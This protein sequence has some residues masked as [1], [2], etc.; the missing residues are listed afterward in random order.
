MEDFQL[1][2]CQVFSINLILE[3]NLLGEM[4]NNSNVIYLKL[5]H[6]CIISLS[7]SFCLW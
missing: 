2:R 5:L 1:F 6:L 4:F 3:I 7:V